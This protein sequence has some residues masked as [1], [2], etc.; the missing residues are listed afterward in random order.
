M[1]K[2]AKISLVFAFGIILAFTLA[3]CD[4]DG[5]GGGLGDGGGDHINTGGN[6]T[7]V[8]SDFTI[9]NLTQIVGSVT[10]VTI[11]PITG[12]STGAITIF[13]NGSTTLPTVAGSYTVTFNVAASTG[14]NAATGL[15]GGTLAINTA[16]QNPVASDFSIGNLT[17]LVGSVIPVTI[18]PLAG[19]S[20]GVITIFYDGS[21]TLP[22]VAGS[23]TV[24]FNVAA[25]T[26]WNAATGLAGGTLAINTA[27]QNPVASDF[28]I[29]NLTQTFGSV[30]PVTIT[31]LA[32][33]S[34]GVITIL[35]NG[36]TT[37]P[38][39][40]GSY[41]VTFNV[42]ASTGWNAA[43]GLA[44]GTLT[45]L[46]TVPE[47]RFEF[48][49]VDQH[50]SL[51]TTSGGAVTINAGNTLTITAQAAGY[52]VSQWHLNGIN[53]GQ[54]G[55]TFNFSS[56]TI[57]KHIIGL[58]VTRGGRLYNTNITITVQ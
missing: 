50:G 52:T 38:T 18:T 42:A 13:Y 34:T 8:A 57:G 19:K 41:T 23:Y 6:Q 39:A 54:S 21:T 40:A 28:T 53:T 51:V 10:P 35:Y 25:S 44:G 56:T 46:Q 3:G 48:Y 15:A 55:D 4:G 9:G 47:N 29:G 27:N 33:R 20:T 16:N 2:L 43:N 14:W 7:P 45:I 5:G 58:F 11:T 17:Q 37:L 49:W 12:K 30:T 24:T 26:G 31:P 32:G 22:T 1:K 36:L